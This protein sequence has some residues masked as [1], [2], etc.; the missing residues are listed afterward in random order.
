MVWDFGI[1]RMGLGKKDTW[2]RETISLANE[3]IGNEENRVGA[4]RW[5]WEGA[6]QRE[7]VDI[8]E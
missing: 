5:D 3:V 1:I 2:Y 7:I 8:W 6:V 4:I